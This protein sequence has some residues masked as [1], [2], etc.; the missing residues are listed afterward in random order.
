MRPTVLPLVGLLIAA[1][2]EAAAEADS[3]AEDEAAAETVE[4][5]AA[6]GPAT[7]GALETSK[8]RRSHFRCDGPEGSVQTLLASLVVVPQLSALSF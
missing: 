2:S 7:E 1:D 5:A 8:A 4:E 6:A 3:V